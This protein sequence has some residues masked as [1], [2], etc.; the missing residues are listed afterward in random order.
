MDDMRMIRLE[1]LK[2]AAKIEIAA[3]EDG[4]GDRDIIQLRED[5]RHTAQRLIDFVNAE[6]TPG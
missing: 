6:R 3:F 2:I 4:D 5:V 1:A